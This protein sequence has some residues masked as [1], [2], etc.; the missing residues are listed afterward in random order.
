MTCKVN[1]RGF[2]YDP[3]KTP[4]WL[5]PINTKQFDVFNDFHRYL[6]VDGPR[7]T[8]KTFGLLHKIVR[9][10]YD[11]NGAMFGIINKTL[12][13]AKSSGIWTVLSNLILPFWEH[14]I[15]EHQWEPWMPVMWKTG[16]PGF[17]V[18][19]GP[20]TTGDTKLSYV[21]IRNRH[22]SISELQC[23]SL[24]HATDV[25]AKFKGPMYS[26]FW[27]S[28]ADQYLDEHAFHILCDALRMPGVRYDEHQIILDMNP[29]DTGPNNFFHDLWFKF[30]ENPPVNDE[31]YDPIFHSGL[32]RIGFAMDDNPQLDPNEKRELI[33]RYKKR[34]TLY[35]RFI[36]GLWEQDLTDG[37]FSEVWDESIHVLGNCQGP[38]SER[39]QIVPTAACRTLLTGWDLGE[40]K[41]HSFHILEKIIAEDPVTKQKTIS[42]SVLD[43]LVVVRTYMSIR[44]FTEIAMAKIAHWSDYQF[45]HQKVRVKWRHWSDTSAFRRRSAAER[46]DSNIV[47]E[48]SRGQII[49]EGA[50]KF[51]DSNKDRVNIAIH[52]LAENRLHVSAQLIKTRLMFANLRRGD[53]ANYV[54]KDDHKHPFD[55]LTYPISAEAPLDMLKSTEIFTAP[56]AI[57]PGVVVAAL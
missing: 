21:K 4:I 47:F 52:L 54:K 30:K 32:H 5:P 36:L 23:H 10:V 44:E 12:K 15:P 24:E 35:N 57:S 3:A 16:C 28:E 45:E 46:S 11:T 19:E 26:G 31:D 51:R 22:G 9:H 7:K 25:E 43:E 13:N 41:N 34:R 2:I 42:F 20:K 27:C 37:H 29:P 39:Q 14:G 17:K 33:S 48:V 8:G 1:S 40:S 53:D 49:L 50:P 38:E 18:V 56:K 6:L 55:S